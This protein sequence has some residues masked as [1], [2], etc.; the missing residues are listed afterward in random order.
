MGHITIER[1]TESKKDDWN[2][3]NASSKAPLFMFD[4]DYME[5]HSDR[6]IDH[7]LMFYDDN[8][9]VAL[10]PMSEKE[11]RLFSHGGLTYGGFITGQRM[12]QAR[13]IECVQQTILYMKEYGFDTMLY[14]CI[15]FIYW[16][17]PAEE[18]Q[19]A[20][21]RCGAKI[22]KI[23]ASTTISLKN[24]LDMAKGRKGKI[25]QAIRQ[26]IVISE[27]EIKDDYVEFIALLNMV[28]N[29]RHGVNA[30]HT[31]DELYLLHTRFPDNIKLITA[32]LHG[33]I[34]AG[35]VL[36][37]YDNVVHTQYLAADNEARQYGALDLVVS[38]TIERYK[39]AVDWLDFGISTENN[40]M[41]LNEGLISQKEGF[42]GRTVAYKAWQINLKQ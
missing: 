41:I 40:G 35:T 18:D 31:A 20:L 24:P 4:R 17:Q 29:D 16:N 21:F 23:E 11:D 37:V 15:P 28:L 34:I 7:S 8:D 26:N 13:M 5:Y 36:Y 3:F 33:K 30:V 25:K 2:A 42:G 39:E 6:F 38:Y 19:Y 22:Y 12:K 32:R 14:K 27:R 9:L 10:L 1:Y